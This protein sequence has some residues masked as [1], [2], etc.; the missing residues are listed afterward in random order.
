MKTLFTALALLGIA[1]VSCKKSD[2]TNTGNGGS[3]G[4]GSNART[5]TVGTRSYT[6]N[7]YARSSETYSAYDIDANSINFTFSSYPPPAGSYR[8]VND[9]ADLGAGQVK[10]YTGSFG[11]SANTLKATGSD[12]ASATVSYVN[13]KIRIVLPETRAAKSPG[14]VDS[15]KISATLSP[16]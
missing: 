6:V 1:V 11:T 7:N 8:V 4:G 15:L 12:G 2:D 5:W 9:T 3:G 14:N 10:V 13:D 16:L